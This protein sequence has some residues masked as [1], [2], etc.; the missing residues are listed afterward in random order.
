[1]RVHFVN[2]GPVFPYAYYLGVI[3]AFR[4]FGDR[5]KLWLV[6]RPS[7]GYLDLLE[8]KIEIVGYPYDV[9]VFPMLKG[10]DGHSKRVATFDNC[11][12]RMMAEQGGTLMGLDSFTLKSFHDL[13][14]SDKQMLVGLDD[15]AGANVKTRWPFCMHGVTCRA[16]SC[17]AQVIY[18]DSTK[19]LHGEC[20]V[21]EHM[22]I[23]G[24][25]LRFGGAGI[26]PF[27]N[28]ALESLE[29]LSIAEFGLLGGYHRGN[30]IP[31]LYIWQEDAEL[32]HPDC[33]TIPLYATSRSA[34]FG[35]ITEDAMSTSN[36]LLPRL[37]RKTLAENEWHP[38]K[39]QE[40]KH[41]DTVRRHRFH[42]LGLVH[43]PVSEIFMGCAFTQKI[44][45]MSKML[46]SLGHEVFLYGAE[47]SDAP[48]SEF[49]QTH[50]LSE[51]RQEW[52]SGDNRFEIGYDWKSE[53]F[54]HDFNKSPAEVTQR[55]Y[56]ACID[57]INERKRADD[58]LLLM[59]GVYQ[60]PVAQGVNL[61]LTCEPGIG[62]R[63]SYARFRAFE[64]AYL[65][66]F[67]YGSEHPK[68]SING[69]YYDRVIPNYFDAKDFPVN[70]G[71]RDNYFFFIGRLIT[72]KGIHTA[73]KTCEAIG[74]K[75]KVAGQ[76]ECPTSDLVEFV[77]YV[78]PDQ[79]AELMGHARAV[80]VPTLYLE[81]FGGVAVEAMLTGTPVL[82]T[83]FGVFASTVLDCVTGFR[84]NTLD[85]FVWGA[86]HVDGLDHATIRRHAERYLMSN[87]QWE[88]Q[89]WFHDL[90][91]LYES[92]M[93]D[94]MKG[95]HRIRGLEPA[96][97]KQLWRF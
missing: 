68:Q 33:R 35:E 84:C 34:A 41:L 46:L 3:S 92:A 20:P 76:G 45:K 87:V 37:V 61:W 42:L 21:G 40:P 88:F 83:N 36:A 39:E 89:R 32:L 16:G 58:F 23:V 25:R 22:A 31:E 48:C 27:L 2:T 62:Y 93:D 24:G 52:G 66:N 94:R 56:R 9:P 1:M 7:R 29:E 67:T 30:P 85:D 63:G 11:A 95:W 64:S 75:L 86:Q 59:Q 78:E 96:W 80:F 57:E 19:A 91:D 10:R 73:I 72:R 50:L 14:E 60:R 6:E 13:L 54:R 49:V 55:Y 90:Y 43:L 38:S 47:S 82:T 51:I 53:G 15:P 12:W 28:H 81:A 8:D 69:H 65:Q 44:V 74:A 18:E 4:A 70:L 97:R 79:R 26:I 17:I 77:G 5:V 71:A